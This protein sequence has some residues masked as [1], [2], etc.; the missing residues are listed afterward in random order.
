MIE[1]RSEKAT[2][3]LTESRGCVIDEASRHLRAIEDSPVCQECKK[4]QSTRTKWLGGT[5]LSLCS[6][7]PGSIGTAQAHRAK[8]RRSQAEAR[9]RLD[10]CGVALHETRSR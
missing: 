9:A 4:R 2:V 7:C 3:R 1:S 5:L 8:V 6:S 10:A